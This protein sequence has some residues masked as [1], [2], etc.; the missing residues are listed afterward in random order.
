MLDTA[1]TGDPGFATKSD[2]AY[3]RVRGLILS[4]ELAPGAVLPQAALAQQIG[5]STT[6]LREALRRLKQEGLVELDAHRDARVRPLDATEARD[7]LELRRSLDPLAASLAAQR[8]TDAD[9]RPAGRARRARGAEHLPVDR[10]AREPPPLPRRHPPCVAQRAAD[11]DPRRPLGEDR[12]LPPARAR[13]RPQRRRARGPRTEHRQLF[14][15]VRDGDADTAADLCAG[16]WRPASA[17]GRPTGWPTRTEQ[18]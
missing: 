5:I 9:R 14:E 4:G 13:D 12:P 10:P 15:A 6:P 7:L 1:P 16:T 17:R 8:R 18:R 11:A 2:L 3:T